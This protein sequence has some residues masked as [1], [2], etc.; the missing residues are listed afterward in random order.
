MTHTIDDAVWTYEDFQPG[1][2]YGSVELKLD[3][4]RLALWKEVYGDEARIDQTGR[5]PRGLLVAGMMETYL[6]VV[7][8]RPPG[9]IHA[10]QK[11]M[12]GSGSL[13]VGDTVTATVTCLDKIRR[14]DRGW[15]T[16]GVVMN[17]N[18]HELLRGEIRTVWAR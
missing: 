13:K 3:E 2:T 9:N 6:R 1:E 7:S 12:L 14:K 18:G 16:I 15:V 10:S 8:P 5:V 17:S 4:T 11:L